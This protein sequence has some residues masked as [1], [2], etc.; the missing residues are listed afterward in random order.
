MVVPTWIHNIHKGRV[1]TTPL[2]R[3]H[4]RP[5]LAEVLCLILYE[6][7]GQTSWRRR[8]RGWKLL[9]IA[10]ALLFGPNKRAGT[11]AMQR[12]MRWRVAKFLAGD[13]DELISQAEWMAKITGDKIFRTSRPGV[14][15]PDHDMEPSS[16]L[17][18]EVS[19]EDA[20]LFRGV[21]KLARQGQLSR[22]TNRLTTHGLAPPTLETLDKLSAKHP[23]PPTGALDPRMWHTDTENTLPGQAIEVDWKRLESVILGASK[24]SAPSITGLRM[25][26]LQ[27]IISGAGPHYTTLRDLLP[28]FFAEVI[29]ADVPEYVQHPDTGWLLIS[30]LIALNK[31]AAQSDVRP[32]ALYD[33]ILKV[34]ERYIVTV[35]KAPL[36]PI[37]QSVGQLAAPGLSGGIEAAA[38]AH[39][40][41]HDMR[42]P[43]T[44]LD[45]SST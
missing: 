20:T 16:E 45:Q 18:A 28:R 34:A 39:R 1:S 38:I 33:T 42:A 12:V 35:E 25:D 5:H 3:D 19:S 41:F 40:T 4:I 13:F 37:F 27:L 17:A 10:P 7:V 36:V 9:A 8:T 30:P 44:P 31:D 6:I 26:H 32:I 11:S 22:A 43:R 15:N 21:Q 23:A 24:H 29:N 2:I 14:R